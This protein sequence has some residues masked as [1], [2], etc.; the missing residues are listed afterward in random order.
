MPRATY[1]V[2]LCRFKADETALNTNLAEMLDAILRKAE[3]H[4]TIG[5]TNAGPTVT[6]CPLLCSILS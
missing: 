5:E 6:R 1:S 3:E 4:E 2:L